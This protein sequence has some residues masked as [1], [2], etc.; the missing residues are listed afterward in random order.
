[1]SG[2]RK[3]AYFYDGTKLPFDPLNFISLDSVGNYHYGHDH[4]M[5]PKR[6]AMTH[7]LINHFKLYSHLHVYVIFPFFIR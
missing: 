7:S 2:K 1:M 4:P 5:K 6:I 3:V